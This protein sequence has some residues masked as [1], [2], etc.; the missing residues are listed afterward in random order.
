MTL[1]PYEP[2]G[3]IEVHQVGSVNLEKWA[4]DAAAVHGMAKALATTSF[5]PASLRGRPD[6]ITAQILYGQDVNL[7]PMVA[8]SQIHIIDGRPSMSALAMRG[9]AQAQGVKFRLDESSEARCRMSAIA[10]GDQGWTTIVWSHDRAKKLG[11]TNKS[12]WTKQPQAML[13]ARATAELCRLVAAPLFLGLSY[14]TE[15][16]RD[17]A[18]DLPEA[19]PYEPAPEP[20]KVR[21]LKRQPIKATASVE[22]KP[23]EQKP[24]PV[25]YSTADTPNRPQGVTVDRGPDPVTEQVRKALMA[26]FNEAG[27]KDRV[28]RLAYVSDLLGREVHSVNQITNDEG[29][30][31]L[32]KL[33]A[34][35]PQLLHTK[36]NLEDWDDVQ[37]AEVPS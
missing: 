2:G 17:G 16:L 24:E 25:G 28:P 4:S 23:D 27:I 15:E 10:P 21:T 9:L 37:V 32:R 5:V 19:M 22:K 31:V 30:R 11:L 12:N 33:V 6:E 34:D 3:A 13:I 20:E 8:L 26:A 35:Y 29:K 14:S 18:D 7:P 1:S 36:T